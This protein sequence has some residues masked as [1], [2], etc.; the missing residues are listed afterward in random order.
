MTEPVRVLHVDDDSAFAELTATYLEQRDGFEVDVETDP[1]AALDR[2]TDSGSSDGSR[3]A[4]TACIDCVVS[5]HEMGTTTG[6]D[7]L[8]SVRA[9]DE[10][11]PFVLFTSRG[12]EEVASEAISAGAPTTSRRGCAPSSSTSSRTGSR[13]PSNTTGRSGDS[14]RASSCTAPSSSGV[15]TPSTSIRAT[16]SDSSTTARAN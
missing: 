14:G 2:L 16:G 13:T 4:G 3:D 6:L 1:E 12:S 9:V 7:L 5:D 11:L 8:K 10:Q 15:T